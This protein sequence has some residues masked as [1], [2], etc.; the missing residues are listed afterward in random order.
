MAYFVNNINI[1]LSFAVLY[2]TKETL[3]NALKICAI[4]AKRPI[5]YKYI[6]KIC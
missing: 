2:H 3:I 6:T 1:S 5:I 4:K